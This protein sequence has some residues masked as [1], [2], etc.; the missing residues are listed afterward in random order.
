MRE[1]VSMTTTAVS[2]ARVASSPLCLHIDNAS[3]RITRADV[4]AARLIVLTPQCD[5]SAI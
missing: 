1:V 3:E 4:L 5:P 2:Y